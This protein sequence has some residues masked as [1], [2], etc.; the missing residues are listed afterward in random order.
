MGLDLA[1]AQ[2]L[3]ELA[4][5]KIESELPGW[6]AVLMPAA[7]LGI[8]TDTTANAVRVRA[9]VLRDWLVDACR[10][11]AKQGFFRFVCFSGHHGPRQLTAIE[12]AG[13]IISRK[14][15]RAWL[16][17]PTLESPMIS[18]YGMILFSAYFLRARNWPAFGGQRGTWLVLA[19]IAR[20]LRRNG[21]GGKRSCQGCRGTIFGIEEN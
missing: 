1:E 19:G 20:G 6:K 8:D 14:P 5:E 12:D 2:R 15:L 4:A 17:K 16:R 13:K 10:A 7:P 3:C 9:H 11:L 21:S 18:P